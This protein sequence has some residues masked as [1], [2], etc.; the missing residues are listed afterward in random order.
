MRIY[1]TLS[2]KI[3]KFNPQHNNIVKMYVC[4]IT[5]Y[6]DTHLG[7]GRCYVVFDIL[8]R[9][10]QYKGFKVEYVQNFTDVDDKILNKSKELSIHPKE[11]SQKY[12]ESYFD[13]EKKSQI[14]F[15]I[16]T[17]FKNLLKTKHFPIIFKTLTV[18]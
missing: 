8:R 4:G 1:N 13:V 2:S 12:I 18:L 10:L 15:L 17:K 9:Y 3:E 11:L 14:N 5:P 16:D 7:H 6:D